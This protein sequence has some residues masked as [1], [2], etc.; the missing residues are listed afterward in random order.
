MKTKVI[1]NRQS[2]NLVEALHEFAANIK[3]FA[4]HIE[5]Y[6]KSHWHD[7]SS[8]T[9]SKVESVDNSIKNKLK[10]LVD[11]QVFF[12]EHEALLA[13]S[14]DRVAII[15]EMIRGKASAFLKE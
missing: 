6:C 4:C 10:S 9:Y 14:K 1:T 13:E 12:R 2:Y 8:L 7:M 5:E 15:K 11:E 3:D